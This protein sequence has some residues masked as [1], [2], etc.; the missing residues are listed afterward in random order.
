[1]YVMAGRLS[2]ISGTG[3]LREL[4]KQRFWGSQEASTITNENVKKSEHSRLYL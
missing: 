4:D 3:A 1:M 2:Q